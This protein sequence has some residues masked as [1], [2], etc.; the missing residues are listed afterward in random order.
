VLATHD[1]VGN[2]AE[3]LDKRLAHKIGGLHSVATAFPTKQRARDE[4][5]PVIYSRDRQI[6][7]G[8]VTLLSEIE[9][10]REGVFHGCLDQKLYH[11]CGAHRR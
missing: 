5:E 8:P 11:N 3:L 2:A 1:R 7:R 10:K 6:F 9:K 4:A